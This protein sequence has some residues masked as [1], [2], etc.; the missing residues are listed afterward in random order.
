MHIPGI[1]R[2]F[3]TKEDFDEWVESVH[4]KAFVELP[5]GILFPVLIEFNV[6]MKLMPADEIDQIIKELKKLA[7]DEEP[8][9]N[10]KPE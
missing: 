8:E 10:S 1:Y 7:D 4:P 2:I 5:E 9:C 6:E 3:K